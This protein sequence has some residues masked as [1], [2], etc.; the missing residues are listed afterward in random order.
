MKTAGPA[1]ARA[2]P[3]TI[4]RALGAI[5]RLQSRL[6]AAER[7]R[8]EPIAIVGL[9]CRL[10][11]GVDSP[12]KYWRL[13]ADGRDAVTE[14]PAERWNIDQYF[15]AD[16]DAP[17]KM[18]SRHGGFLQG[19]DGFDSWFFRISP[20]EAQ[21]L[22]P[23]QRLLLEV[24]WEAL[25]D[26]GIAADT[27]RGTATGVFIGMTTNDY[28]QLLMRQGDSRG[29]DA[30]FFT[31]NPANA[32]AGRLAYTFGFQGPAMA[33]DTAC[34][35][36]LVSVH[37]ACASLRSG[38]CR[39]ALAGGVNLVLSPDNT[40]AVCKT[41]AL[42]TTGACRTF[43]RT[44]DGFV[45]SEGCGLVLLKRLSDAIADGDS[46]RAVIRGSAVNQDG[47]SSGFT[48]PNG[49]AQQTVI[50][51]ALGAI[52]PADIDYLE[53][54][55]TGTPLGDPIEVTAATAVLGEGRERSRPLYIG[56]VKTNLG[57][58]EAAAGIAALIKTV[59]ALQH[60]AIPPHLHL[61]EPNPLISWDGLPVRVPQTLTPWPR[62]ARP[63]LAG[64]SAFGASGTNAH[65]VLEE[66]PLEE[67]V[68]PPAPI[69][70]APDRTRHVLVLS[71]QRREALPPLIARYRE[72]LA[73]AEDADFADIC[74]SAATGRMHGRHRMTVVAAS[75]A[76]AIAQLDALAIRLTSGGEPA[77]PD[78]PPRAPRLAFLFTGQGSQYAGMSRTLYDTQPVFR[79]AIDRCDE[80]LAAQPV[81]ADEVR[82]SLPDLLFGDGS[83]LDDTRHTQP[84]LFALET[85]LVTMLDRWGVRPAVVMGHSVGEFAAAVA[86]GVCSLADGLTL[87]HERARLMG[88]LAQ[89]GAMTA[90]AAG[91]PQVRQALK[92]FET[93]L[94]IAAINGPQSVVVSGR[95]TAMVH[96]VNRLSAQGIR[97]VPL[98]VSHAFHSPLMDPILDELTAAA[99]ALTYSPPTVPWISNLTGQPMAAAPDAAYWR[100]Q[101]RAAVRFSDGVD[102]LVEQRCDVLLE[103]GPRPTLV[104]LAARCRHDAG[105]LSLASLSPGD[106]DWQVLLDTLAALYGRGL[107]PDWRAFDRPYRRRRVALPTYPF[108]RTRYWVPKKDEPMQKTD[109]LTPE[110]DGAPPRR[111]AVLAVLRRGI[112]T[113]LQA[114]ESEINI[115]LPFLEMGADSLV[116]V[117]AIGLIEQ[118]FGLK[119]TIRRF[120]ED[121]SSIDALAQ[122]I[123]SALPS[124]NAAAPIRQPMDAA[125]ASPE[126]PRVPAPPSFEAAQVAGAVSLER[127]LLEQTRLMT[128]FLAQQADIMRLAVGAAPTSMTA[129]PAL[130]RVP[131]PMDPP[132]L[133]GS[134]GSVPGNGRGAEVSSG[135][136]HTPAPPPLPW[137]DPV[138]LRARGLTETQH[139]HLE[140][141]IERYTARTPQSKAH[142]QHYRPVLA[143][144]RATVGFR[145]STKEMLYPIW[146]ARS[147]GSR[148]WDIDGNEYIDFTMG[149]GVHLFGHKPDFI[150]QAL[151]EDLERAVELGTR[152]HLAGEVAALMT[153]LTGLDRVAFCNSGTEAVMA[154]IRLA[155]AATGR[156][157]IAIFTN[158]YHG[159]SD[160]TLARAQ[161]TGGQLMSVPMAPGVP[162][163][164]AAD[165]LVLDYGSEQALDIIRTRGHELAAVLVE[166][167]Q[168][169]NLKQQPGAF[170][171]ELRAI[172][173]QVGAALI[174]DEMITGFRA[175][176]G[177]AQAYFGVKADLATYGKIAGGGMPIGLV[178]GAAAFMDGVDGGMWQYG[179]GSFPA[180]DRTA[181][182]GTFCQHPLAMAAARAVLRHVKEQGPALQRR[183]NDRTDRMVR[184]LNDYF[185]AEDVPIEA[186]NFS[187][188]FRFEFSSNLDLLFYHMLEKGIFI[189]EWRSCFLS[190]AHS[191]EDIQRFVDVVQESIDDLR[192]GGFAPR[193]PPRAGAR[194][195]VAAAVTTRTAPLS[196][197]QR[198][199]WLLLQIEETASIAYNVS[200]TVELRGALDAG[201]L[202]AALQR[203]VDRHSA[204]RSTI[205]ADGAGQIVHEPAQI[206]LPLT[207]LSRRPA[208]E[209]DHAVAR[210]RDD[211]GRQPIDLVRGPVFRPQLVRLAPD[212]HELLLTAHHILADG[213]TM[214]VVMK[215]LAAFY[216]EL[217]GGTPGQHAVPMQFS[218]YVALCDQHRDSPPMK[219]HEAFWLEQF[220]DGVPQLDLPVDRI[221][222][223]VKTYAGGRVIRQLDAATLAALQ[224]VSREHACTL[225]MTLLTAFALLLHRFTGQ[226]DLV[227]GT[228][229]SGRPFPGSQEVAGYCTHL[230]PVR[231]RLH[232]DP[233]F[234]EQLGEMKRRLLDVFDHQDLPFSALLQKLPLARPAGSFPLISAV[235]NLEPAPA[236][237]EFHGL[238]T[239]LLPQAVS[240]TP[241]D[242]FVNVTVVG[243]TL[244]VETDLNAD[245][246]DES[247]VKRMMES[248]DVLLGGAIAAPSAPARE[249]PLLT[250]A[251]RHRVMVEWNDT[252]RPYPE[253]ARVHRMFEQWASVQ[254]GAVAL[255]VGGDDVT[256]GTL[257]AR[258]NQL[259][260]W[261]RSRGVGPD[262][263]VGI[264]CERSLEM[265]TA[266]LGVIKA[267]GAYV[268]LDPE[269]PASRLEFMVADAGAPIVLT[270]ARWADRLQ[271][272]AGERFRLDT[273]WAR[274]ESMPTGN[275]AGEVTGDQLAYMIYTSGSTGR[276]KGALNTHRGIANR[277]LWMQD[278]YPLTPDDRV[279]QKTPFSFDVSVWELLWP[280]TAG[281]RVVMAVPGGHRDPA[282]LV[283]LIDRAQITTI[284]FVPSML[285]AFLEGPG[286]D[287]CGSLKRVICSGEALPPEL[288]RRFTAALDVPIHNL[289][290]PTEAAV[291]VTAWACDAAQVRST[292]P[293][294]KPIAN[295]Q[296]YVFDARRQPVPIGVTGEI[297][298]GGVGVGRGYLNRPELT[299]QRFLPDPARPGGH[300]YRTGDLARFRADGNI[301]YL[302]RVDHQVKI[303]GFRIELGEIEAGLL[304]YP[305]VTGA[306]VVAQATTAGGQ[307][308][309]AY[310]A[311]ADR[312]ETLAASLHAH[313]ARTLPDYMVPSAFVALAA[314]P[315]LQNGK[316]DRRQLPGVAVGGL[317]VTPE[318]GV[319]SDVAAVWEEVLRQ[320]PIGATDDFFALG[321]NSLS[322]GQVVSRIGGRLETRLGVKDIFRYPTVRSLAGAIRRASGRSF[323]PI[324]PLAPQS[325]YELSHA[326]RRFWI[327]DQIANQDRGNSQ[328]ACFLI[329]GELNRDALRRA[330]HAV[331]SRH[332]MLRTVF[333]QKDGEPRQRI[334][335]LT[336]IGFDLEETDA[337][338][339]ADAELSL[340]TIVQRQAAAR[341]DLATGPLFRAQLVRL[342]R[343]RHVAVCSMHHTITDGWSAGVLLN[344]VTVLYD[345]FVSGRADPLPP[346]AIQYKDYA[347]WQNQ[348]TGGAAAEAMRAYWRAKLG[349]VTPLMLPADVTS[350]GGHSRAVSRFVLDRDLVG[351]LEATARRQGATLFMALLAC[352]KALLYR[353]TAQD[354]I[355]VGT[356]VSTRIQPELE[357]QIGPYLNI[358]ALRDRVSGDDSL[359]SVLSRVRD[360]T[361]DAFANQLYPFDRVVDD[362][363]LKRI[364]GRNPLFDVGFTLQNQHEVQP[365]EASRHVR[366]SEMT[367]TDESLADPE[368][369]TDLWFLARP[370]AGAL[371]MQ[372]V[373][374]RSRFRPERI[375]RLSQDLQAM[376]AAAATHPDAT[377]KAVALTAGGTRDAGRKITIN[378]GL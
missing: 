319:E 282:Y 11:G 310:V 20:R 197:A 300:L 264:C 230:V 236:S 336:A 327:Q 51:Q 97:A 114:P 195:T 61:R 124:A 248:Y 91:E 56:S 71:A 164:V 363:Q 30:F 272:C 151:H 262:R 313:L 110:V 292:V 99:G 210:W 160:A 237:L 145:L 316:I 299:E 378:L 285:G 108:H 259:A 351:P 226:D 74:Y 220:A 127:I 322:A 240:F 166:P 12:E 3:S 290:G 41:R 121:L 133:P 266:V 89:D 373:Y 31:G 22:D 146:G 247:T 206:D 33:I 323:P 132:T 182:G 366:M 19:V 298:I 229:V 329:E 289:Y 93:D 315:L 101:C 375:D 25:E 280:L 59:L 196:D 126:Q 73:S 222:P 303:R 43:D 172:T 169:R 14:V 331:V 328:P 185:T 105:W 82:M 138:D 348:I 94:S 278:T 332:D 343:D 167:V 107:N 257:N 246:F 268:P 190:V 76:E 128:Q 320:T 204:L 141:L 15:D 53:A 168:S 46:I 152:S 42:S 78:E 50:R 13:L 58:C 28:A 21:S 271:G 16:P 115:N 232:G 281:A 249:L 318:A 228:S 274:L 86:A 362:L 199:L 173:R 5:D 135:K 112:A 372:V 52:A 183:L 359:A 370:D 368:A 104:R 17:G 330:F 1:D 187:S 159:H 7:A 250:P 29:L 302:G 37:Q 134:N 100:Q 188:L 341:M 239:Q 244:V 68:R 265:L 306:V 178:A 261:L 270:Q 180:A 311:T 92:G 213:I 35:S 125:P 34:S 211:A 161:N 321:G 234:S 258:A 284:H 288:L 4:K 129:R 233:S 340:Q 2:G 352:I 276:P 157:K 179:D 269:Y 103:I 158:A 324:A 231:S 66:A 217:V 287:R 312:P 377:I 95:K 208:A 369:A 87:V 102:A 365:R 8:T 227:V 294:G 254:P 338:D 243:A 235:F 354:D 156:S 263:L 305:G 176:P 117:E 174:F 143:D 119:V 293:I 170:L 96:L 216:N 27:L 333:I 238:T 155:R 118:E 67:A 267:G 54:H 98:T 163:A 144:S 361:L 364:P 162:G 326:E 371:A 275:Q 193:P 191:D 136:A 279:L 286:L 301:E 62:T 32:A 63:R 277:L 64:V 70:A 65:L 245:L 45:R 189:W 139:R 184:T 192:R 214:A 353:H 342:G 205:A 283:D 207:D 39:S 36:S 77:D 181:F 349:G 137:G 113:L 49:P 120:F 307:R 376:V 81:R 297:Y 48:V 251:T 339:A 142:T 374:D 295:S 140:A 130:D 116:M 256:Y 200:T 198:Q 357:T 296:I 165:I 55:G 131:A 203:V 44:A 224:R 57:H 123:E 202:R 212:R 60:Q 150:Q 209:R 221:R 242:L 273:D 346:L 153:E 317:H 291:D 175:D 260:C 253:N 6:D 223:P 335:S 308:L 80:I 186:T 304:E 325:D 106:D 218:E 72:R 358:L 38:E 252:A 84:A 347:A 367:R 69:A 241:F 9:A 344:D 337:A 26:A 85:A 255:Q 309:V 88:R 360:T 79:D 225:N 122:Y 177:G 345:A 18:Y 148:T 23:Q 10:P 171:H 350:P 356:P 111:A 147:A 201:A 40:V 83:P 314:I 334:L 109:R 219:A 215:E 90:V 154:A 149:F 75:A 47:A 24:A 194:G 355:T